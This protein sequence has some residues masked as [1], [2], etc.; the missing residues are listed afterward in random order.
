M[1]IIWLLLE[2]F[3]NRF[4]SVGETKLEFPKHKHCPHRVKCKCDSILSVTQTEILQVA[5]DMDPQS[6][7]NIVMQ[8]KL[9][10]ICMYT[11]QKGS[12]ICRF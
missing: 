4:I 1:A 12:F 11:C 10:N 8:A 2:L 7:L 9:E 3:P 5:N 6:I